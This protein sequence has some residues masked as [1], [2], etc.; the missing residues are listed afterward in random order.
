M[1][2][3]KLIKRIFRIPEFLAGA[4]WPCSHTLLIMSDIV[5]KN[6]LEVQKRVLSR[7]RN[8]IV[9]ANM[10]EKCHQKMRKCDKK[11]EPRNENLRR[12][13]QRVAVSVFWDFFSIISALR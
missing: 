11:K 10:T 6:S 4:R 5:T 1:A 3:R 8:E 13:G 9:N 12:N 7:F 2:Y